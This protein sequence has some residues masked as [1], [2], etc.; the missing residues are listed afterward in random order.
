MVMKMN[1]S[2]RIWDQHRHA[3]RVPANVEGRAPAM[4]ELGVSTS[5]NRCVTAYGLD[6]AASA[7]PRILTRAEL[8]DHREPLAQ[9]IRSAADE[10]DRLYNVVGQARY[11]VLLCDRDGVAIDYRAN[12]ADAPHFRHWGIYLG[13]VWSEEVEGTN[14]IGTSIS[15]L[16]TVTVHGAQHFRARHISLSCSSAPIL[17]AHGQLMAV[18]DVS[19]FDPSISDRAHALT[20]ALVMA[21]ARAIE[22]RFFREGGAAWRSGYAYRRGGLPPGALKRVL[23]YV[24][25]H[26][27]ER[28]STERLAA[29]AG[30]SVF[31]FA[32][33]FKQSQG[34]TP[35]SY[36]LHRRIVRAQELLGET[37]STL[38]EIALVSGFA[39]QSHLARHFRERVGVSPAIFRRSQR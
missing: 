11:V 14:A 17:D 38:S 10:L 6:P 22:E 27:A 29:I 19:C 25:D 21:S 12:A 7:P 33:A 31:H 23:Q 5:W 15:E 2:D 9:L 26:L 32:R 39:D 1:R 13:G 37:E 20:G 36:L 18:L 34:M 4:R 8:K 28:V 30:L 35:H 3:D 16:R 24:E